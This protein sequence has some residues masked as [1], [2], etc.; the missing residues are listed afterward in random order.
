MKNKFIFLF[1]SLTILLTSCSPTVSVETPQRP[2]E[3]NMNVKIDHEL[4]VKVEK[5]VND[6]ISKNPNLF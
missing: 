6:L 1:P 3:I 5:D 2:I 4:R